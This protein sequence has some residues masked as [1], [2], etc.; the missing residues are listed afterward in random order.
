MHKMRREVQIVKR[1]EQKNFWAQGVNIEKRGVSSEVWVQ[2]SFL[3]CVVYI[4][5]LGA[6]KDVTASSYTSICSSCTSI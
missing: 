5:M 6:N 3:K 2:I 4:W 1:M